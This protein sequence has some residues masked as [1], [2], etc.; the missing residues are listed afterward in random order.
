MRWTN[1]DYEIDDE[2]SR[3]DMDRI[4]GWLAKSYW[5]RHTP[6]PAVRRSWQRSGVVFGLYRGDE[7]I[8]CARAVT[9]FARFAYLS[10]VFVEP[11]YRGHGLGRWLVQTM[12][13]HPDIPAV[14]WVL[15]TDDAHGLYGQLGFEPAD[16]TVMQRPRPATYTAPPLR[17]SWDQ[18]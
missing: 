10:D 18:G 13:E 6:E 4:V 11:E 17:S 3:L 9:D 8:G 5:A 16:E 2:R 1:G 15:H 12:I 7:L 14:R